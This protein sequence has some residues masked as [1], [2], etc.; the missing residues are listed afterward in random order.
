MLVILSTQK[1][2]CEKRINK[3]CRCT[4]HRVEHIA[5]LETKPQPLLDAFLIHEQAACLH[6]F[7]KARELLTHCSSPAAVGTPQIQLIS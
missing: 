3:I 7:R 5:R 2:F 4:Q 6:D 1:S